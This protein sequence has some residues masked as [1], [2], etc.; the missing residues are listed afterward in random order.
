[1]SN[2][3]LDQELDAMLKRFMDAMNDKLFTPI[4][5]EELHRA[6]KV[7]AIGKSPRLSGVVIE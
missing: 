2:A 1:M 5:L 4:L 6:A 3:R 7:M